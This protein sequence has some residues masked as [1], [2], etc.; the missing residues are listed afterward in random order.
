[1][2]YILLRTDKRFAEPI[3]YNLVVKR[4]LRN[5]KVSDTLCLKIN[6]I[7]NEDGK[8]ERQWVK[9]EVVEVK[10][11]YVIVEVVKV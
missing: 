5:Y 7:V 9:V 4:T 10:G 11:K 8:F 1:M 3:N 6:L 2:K